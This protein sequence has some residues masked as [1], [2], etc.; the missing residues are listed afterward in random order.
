ML[1]QTCDAIRG[2]LDAFAPGFSP[3]DPQSA[4]P[5]MCQIGIMT[6]DRSIQFYN[7]AK[8]LDQ[9]QMMVVGDIEDPFVPLQNGFLVN[10]TANRDIILQL[11]D[12]IPIIF[13]DSKINES[14]MG[15]A[16]TAASIALVNI[17]L[18]PHY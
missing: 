1:M 18:S 12:Q 9:P 4:G 5:T 10:P 3:D 16:A 6:Y 17:Q 14:A 7:L 13:K 8:G 2:I 11:L 15:S